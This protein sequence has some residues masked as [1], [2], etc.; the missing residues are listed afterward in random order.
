MESIK[1][2]QTKI[3]EILKGFNINDYD[4]NQLLEKI[5][6][7]FLREKIKQYN[8]LNIE[9]HELNFKKLLYNKE[10]NFN[11]IEEIIKE[12]FKNYSKENRINEIIPYLVTGKVFNDNKI[13]YFSLYDFK[14]GKTEEEL[15]TDIE[16]KINNLK[17]IPLNWR[18][19][20]YYLKENLEGLK[21]FLDL[22]FKIKISFVYEYNKDF[23]IYE[24]E[25]N[26][27]NNQIKIKCFKEWFYLSFN[28]KEQEKIFKNLLI[29]Q[30]KKRVLNS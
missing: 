23:K 10:F 4:L 24:T 20:K 14:K 25:I 22:L 1:E 12:E 21:Q 6:K 16:N 26:K 15:K 30:I 28:N 17:E 27:S 7:D 2:I 3:K 13:K 18:I 19:D 8:I 5:K 29:K 9:K 11:K